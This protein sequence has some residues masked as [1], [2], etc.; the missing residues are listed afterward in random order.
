MVVILGVYSIGTGL[1]PYLW[2]CVQNNN[3]F[4]HF[5]FLTNPLNQMTDMDF[6]EFIADA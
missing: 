1:N 5:S 4:N 2:E 6:F 3:G